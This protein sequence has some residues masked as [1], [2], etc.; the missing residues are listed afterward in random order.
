MPEARS[1]TAR[2]VEIEQ[3]LRD[4]VM[5][6]RA[7]DPLPSEAELATQF[8]VSRMTARQAVQNL[9]AEGLVRRRR[10]SG[11]F[12]APRRLHRHSGPLMSFTADMHR[13][14]M[15]ASSRLLSAELR[16]AS[17]TEIESLHL[18]EPTR[19]VSISRLRLADGTPMALETTALTPDCAPV[20]AADLEGGSLHDALREMGRQPTLALSWIGARIA[21]ASEA[22]LFEMSGRGA[23]L[24]ERRV[25]SD[26]DER[27][28][29]GAA[30]AAQQSRAPRD[31]LDA[32]A[33]PAAAGGSVEFDGL[34]TELAS[35]PLPA[36]QFAI[37][38]LRSAKA[39]PAEASPS[40]AERSSSFSGVR[41][42][43]K[44]RWPRA[45][46]RCAVAAAIPVEPVTTTA[47]PLIARPP[48][49]GRAR[50]RPMRVPLRSGSRRRA[51]R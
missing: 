33:V 25:I 26:Q 42:I 8:G 22:K 30:G 34:V 4:R 29:T 47:F 21:T 9:A 13:R 19:V 5:A 49:S 17:P 31:R 43:V 51:R 45:T 23:L 39:H 46:R 38:S 6:G 1:K 11:T 2:Y 40:A 44:T 50:P 3:W 37:S 27:P 36:P 18:T 24:I 41:A 28:H 14:G 10:G 7:G 32:S 12:I 15:R 20:L 16:E 35:G 48:R